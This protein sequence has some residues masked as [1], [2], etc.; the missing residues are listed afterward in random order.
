MR[1][2]A[3]TS[4]LGTFGIAGC[5]GRL[6]SVRGTPD[7]DLRVRIKGP[8]ES[9]GSL[10]GSV[11]N[12]GSAER[13][14]VLELAFSNETASTQQVGFGATPPFSAYLGADTTGDESLLLVPLNASGSQF[15]E[16]CLPT[17]R[18]DGCWQALAVPD[19][20]DVRRERTLGP[21]ESLRTE[22]AL[23][24]PPDS[25]TCYAAGTYRFTDK[26]TISADTR[27]WTVVVELA[28]GFEP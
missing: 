19:V 11:V 10:S 7:A 18:T 15:E 23:L 9:R 27:E 4:A 16:C 25:S 13:F 20:L 24:V 3:F 17:T 1:R 6:G 5:T 28:E 22:Y 26:I 21:G 14:P 8:D 2:R 12:S